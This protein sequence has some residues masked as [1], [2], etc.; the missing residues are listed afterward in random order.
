MFFFTIIQRGEKLAEIPLEDHKTIEII[1]SINWFFDPNKPL[2]AGIDR[3][4]SGQ[5]ARVLGMKENQ[6]FGLLS[7]IRADNGEKLRSL[8]WRLETE[9]AKQK[10]A[11]RKGK[12]K[13][14]Q[15]ADAEIENTLSE[16]TK[17]Y[18]LIVVEKFRVTPTRPVRE[19]LKQNFF[20]EKP[21]TPNHEMRFEKI[22]R[23]KDVN[24][25]FAQGKKPSGN[26]PKT[27]FGSFL[28]RLKRRL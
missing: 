24:L 16:L 6:V 9:K 5:L 2:P 15:K 10:K 28:N 3:D 18:R 21:Q 8:R 17:I 7:G 14:A 22:A 19:I 13:N 25:S 1:S 23:P 12:T 20:F 27:G 26:E 11:L 4:K